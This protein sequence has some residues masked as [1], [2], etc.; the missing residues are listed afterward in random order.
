MGAKV[1]IELEFETPISD[2]L[3]A[4]LAH[5]AQAAGKNATG[6]PVKVIEAK[7]VREKEK[8]HARS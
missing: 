3:A 5:A 2:E 7:V 8:A 1:R 6:R 4:T